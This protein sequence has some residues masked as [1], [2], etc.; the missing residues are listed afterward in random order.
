[1]TIGKDYPSPRNAYLRLLG[2]GFLSNMGGQ[3]KD[4][5]RLLAKDLR[6]F[7]FGVQ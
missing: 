3:F 2:S 4:G 7:V 6:G 5:R 1:M